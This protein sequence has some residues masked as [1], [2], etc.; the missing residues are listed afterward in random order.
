M[1][2]FQEKEETEA[3]RPSK[4]EALDLAENLKGFEMRVV[5]GRKQY[6]FEL[7]LEKIGVISFGKFGEIMVA[8]PQRYWQ[9]NEIN[10]FREWLAEKDQ[11]T[12][13]EAYAEERVAFQERVAVMWKEL[14][15]SMRH[16]VDKQKEITSPALR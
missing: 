16:M 8:S 10:S 1:P 6:P 5:N 15:D 11:E 14:K 9:L 3:W 7:Y 2:K 12:F 13:F 4:R